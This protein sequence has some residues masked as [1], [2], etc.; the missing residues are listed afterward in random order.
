MG[1]DVYAIAIAESMPNLR[2]LQVLGNDQ[3][4]IGLQA[5]LDSCLDL[6][7]LDLRRC[8][9]LVLLAEQ[10]GHECAGRIKILHLPHESVDGY[11]SKIS[12]ASV[13]YCF[14]DD[15]EYPEC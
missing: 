11:D 10:L 14:P 6:E 12:D 1:C 7:S 15:D 3:T 2:H 5:I 13:D 4:E 9:K 8:F